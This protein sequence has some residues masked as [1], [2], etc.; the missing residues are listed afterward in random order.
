[1]GEWGGWGAL[2][3]SFYGVG[4]FPGGSLPRG[5]AVWGF[6]IRDLFFFDDI[7][8]CLRL[9]LCAII[10]VNTFSQQLT[11]HSLS[12]IVLRLSI[13]VP[14]LIKQGVVSHFHPR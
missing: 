10:F 8:I 7:D 2:V 4:G 6:E 11:S 3:G 13:V 9:T 5:R 14:S 12:V 1:M